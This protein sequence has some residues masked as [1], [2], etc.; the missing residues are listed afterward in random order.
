MNINKF[1]AKKGALKEVDKNLQFPVKENPELTETS[2]FSDKFRNRIG[3]LGLLTVTSLAGAGCKGCHKDDSS[4]Y[5]RIENP[6]IDEMEKNRQ[7]E[8]LKKSCL[9]LTCLS[10]NRRF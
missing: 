6:N 7:L 3:M 4:K 1:L 10:K 8:C 5:N 9:R 2:K